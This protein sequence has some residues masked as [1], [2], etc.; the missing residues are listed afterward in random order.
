MKNDTFDKL[1][2]RVATV[3]RLSICK[4]PC[5]KVLRKWNNLMAC[6]I[7]ACEDEAHLGAF[8]EP[9]EEFYGFALEVPK[10][11]TVMTE[12]LM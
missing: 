5:R 8:T 9:D 10:M 7:L 3:L 11:Y 6:G 4:L 1:P 12:I 2:F